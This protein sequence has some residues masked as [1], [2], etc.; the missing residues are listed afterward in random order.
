M[1]SDGH[2]AAQVWDSGF[3]S[4]PHSFDVADLRPRLAMLMSGDHKVGSAETEPHHSNGAADPRGLWDGRLCDSS[5]PL[6]ASVR[7]RP[8]SSASDAAFLDFGLHMDHS[9]ERLGRGAASV[10][11]RTEDDDSERAS[12]VYADP[13]WTHTTQAAGGGLRRKVLEHQEVLSGGVSWAS[14]K[15]AGVYASDRLTSARALQSA[16]TVFSL[17]GSQ[18]PFRHKLQ[19]CR[20]RQ[21]QHALAGHGTR[22]QTLRR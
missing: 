6:G 21:Q 7:E 12:E 13:L 9:E 1:S 22:R 11:S 2:A 19:A 18:L 20:Q 16:A 8:A 14:E 3:I 15:G 17:N 5:P 10:N 4:I